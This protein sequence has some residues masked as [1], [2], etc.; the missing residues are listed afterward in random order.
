M[1]SEKYCTTITLI[2]RHH[3]RYIYA[4]LVRMLVLWIAHISG[5]TLHACTVHLNS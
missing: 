5:N 3:V 4:L 2:K 1:G